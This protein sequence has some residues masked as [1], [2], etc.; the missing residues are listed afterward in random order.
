M[1]KEVRQLLVGNLGA[2]VYPAGGFHR[3]EFVVRFGRWKPSN[4]RFYCSEFIPEQ[5]LNDLQL[6]VQQARDELKS[7]R[8]SRPALQ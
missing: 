6:I 4:G 2:L 7:L 8:K 1:P 3:R 5:E